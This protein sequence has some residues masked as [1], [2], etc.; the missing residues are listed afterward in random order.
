MKMSGTQRIRSH[1]FDLSFA[2]GA[3]YAAF[4]LECQSRLSLA[5]SASFSV[6]THAQSNQIVHHVA[7]ELTPGFHLMNLQTF[8]G[9]THLTPPTISF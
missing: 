3:H 5:A 9:T 2:L 6:A 8:H 7:A 4:P 1:R